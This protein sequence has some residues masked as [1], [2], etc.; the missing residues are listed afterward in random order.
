MAERLEVSVVHVVPPGELE[1]EGADP[2]LVDLAGD[3]HVAVCRA[4]GEPSLL[5][6]VV[7]FL[8]RRPIE[9]VTLVLDRP[10]EAE[11]EL[12]VTV[13]ETDLPGVYEVVEE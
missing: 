13:A 9:A 5:E 2:A 6:R 1:S 11:T 10:V 12:S 3:R 7:A 4:G 8:R